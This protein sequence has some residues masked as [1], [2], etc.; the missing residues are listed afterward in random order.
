MNIKLLLVAICLCL[1]AFSSAS[2][3]GFAGLGSNA[4]GFSK[5][6]RGRPITFPTD[7]GA[8]VDY[9]IEWWYV[10]A[11]L[12]AEDGTQLGAQWT[13]FRQ[14]T[15][16]GT[17]NSNWSS[18]EFWLGHAA[19]TSAD[20]HLVAE[21]F[22]RGGSGQAGAKNDRLD[23]WIDD[24]R[25]AEK[26]DGEGLALSAHGNRFSYNLE[27]AE[28]GPIVFHGD[29]GFSVKS[30]QGQA[31]YYFSHPFLTAEGNVTIDGKTFAVS[32]HAWLDREWSS[33]PLAGNQKGWDWFSLK[34]ENG[35]RL[36]LFGLRDNDGGSYRSGSWISK[37]GAL[38]PLKGSD[39]RLT[40]QSHATVEGRD[41]PVSWQ[42]SVL[43][44]AV[45]LEVTAL[46]RDS[47]MHTSIP[48]WEGPVVV[49]GSH[50]AIGY[51]EMT[52]Y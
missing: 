41:I 1:P 32:G 51:L 33:Q 20:K 43:S 37:D 3:Q 46:N 15:K 5:V 28:H 29:N 22:A 30:D 14:A 35:E 11:N 47:W 2:G 23:T 52:G 34:F 50:K 18:H 44:K 12:E 24:W 7:Y 16:P 31:S 42:V 36:M 13:L 27:L 4:D 21:K 17:P 9:R 25:F 45:D 26:R 6:V 40:P 19:I 39:I 48:Y 10:T 8:H 38:T 49:E